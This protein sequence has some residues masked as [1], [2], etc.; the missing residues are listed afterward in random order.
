MLF[1]VL[2]AAV[3]HPGPGQILAGPAFERFAAQTD[4]SCPARRWRT[5]TPGDLSG[6]QE[7]FQSSL[8]P[9]RRTQLAA[10]SRAGGRCTGRNGLSCPVGETL[11]AMARTNLLH[12]F[13]AFACAHR[14]P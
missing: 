3:A 4:R 2:A 6:V 7:D 10:A 13:A 12:R 8:P 14:R 9:R 5:V 11:D 1:L